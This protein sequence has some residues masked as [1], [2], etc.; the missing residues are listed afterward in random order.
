MARAFP[1]LPNGLNMKIEGLQ[2]PF[3]E[4]LLPQTEGVYLVGGSIRDLLLDRHSIDYDIAVSKNP[5]LFA[6]RLS[7]R[8]GGRLVRFGKPGQALFR[9][10]GPEM[11]FDVTAVRGT[12]IEADLQERDF[13][14]NAM[15]YALD[16]KIFIDP[17]NGRADLAAKKLTI[18]SENV[19][20][21]DPVRLVR[22]YRICAVYGLRMDPDTDFKIR[23]ESHR[24][25][26][27]PPERITGE[28]I[29][30]F[31]AS[32]ISETISQMARS[33]LLFHIL[34]ELK[35]TIGC[36]QNRY[37]AFNVFEHTFKA[38]SHL[39]R[40]QENLEAF[41]PKAASQIRKS[42]HEKSFTLLKWAMLLH[43]I[44]K[45]VVRSAGPEG[46]IHFGGHEKTGAQM[47]ADICRRLR[48]SNADTQDTVFIIRNHVRPLFLFLACKNPG[49]SRRIKIR[50]F[51]R[52]GDYTPAL[53]LH[54]VADIQG[55]SDVPDL[56]NEAFLSFARDLVWEYFEDYL[57]I[58][59]QVPL[60]TGFDL[61]REFDLAPSPIMKKIL[62][63][64]REAQLSKEILDR[65]SAVRLARDMIGKRNPTAESAEGTLRG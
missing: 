16:S 51:L 61:I 45:P 48:F 59:R 44:G 46:K 47:A 43:D 34:P 8:I 33:E 31:S 6:R 42:L 11:V 24:I 53:L 1:R 49:F 27:S 2:I 52:C 13:T 36:T 22:A 54:A 15:A 19:F 25:R 32:N 30:I 26:E 17:F 21:K 37:H 38:L 64:I 7:N 9:I 65:A 10:V 58:K 4:A 35:E 18:V 57:E 12:S 28:L 20:E 62:G 5:D 3:D 56:R 14:I 40:L 23:M 29:R 50:F 41:F 63:R 55:K 60:I 39:E